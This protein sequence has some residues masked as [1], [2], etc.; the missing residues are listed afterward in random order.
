MLQLNDSGLRDAAAW[1]AAGY[2]LPG[3]DR[4]AMLAETKR[5]PRWVHFGAGNIFKAFQA[6]C[7]QKLLNEGRLRTGVVA[8]ERSDS[9]EKR[10]SY[11]AH[12]NLT[13]TVEKLA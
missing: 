1:R 11:D 12:D 7:A 8:V 9:P 2:A 6:N 13:V 5:A 3:Y 4:A 10:T